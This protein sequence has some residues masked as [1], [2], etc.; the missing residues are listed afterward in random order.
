MQDPNAPSKDRAEAHE[1]VFEQPLHQ[2]IFDELE[3][4]LL[5]RT[6][7]DDDNTPTYQWAQLISSQISKAQS[8]HGPFRKR[9]LRIAELAIAAIASIDRKEVS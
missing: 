3:I 9:Y 8:G 4:R 1:K 6:Q 7:E 5:E 2:P